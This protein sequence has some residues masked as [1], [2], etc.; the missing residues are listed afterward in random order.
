MSIT[1]A[2]VF[3]FLFL[4]DFVNCNTSDVILSSFLRVLFLR[5]SIALSMLWF[6]KMLNMLMFTFAVSFPVSLG[7]LFDVA[8]GQLLVRLAARLVQRDIRFLYAAGF[9]LEEQCLLVAC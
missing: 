2:S 5:I 9:K 7:F 3:S 6:F 4:R 8:S 1:L